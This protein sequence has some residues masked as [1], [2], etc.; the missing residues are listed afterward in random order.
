MVLA[1]KLASL[2]SR[3]RGSLDLDARLPPTPLA[4]MALP[5]KVA[6]ADHEAIAAPTTEQLE[7]WLF[8]RQ[9]RSGESQE[10]APTEKL[11]EDSTRVGSSLC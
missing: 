8:R 7:E 6:Q 1:P 2:L 3:S 10:L 5:A 9:R 11:C 4:A